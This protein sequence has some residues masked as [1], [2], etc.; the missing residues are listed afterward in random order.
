MNQLSSVT[1][2]CPTLC[3][4]MDCSTPGFPDHHQ[5]PELVQTHVHRVGDAIQPLHPLSS[6]SPAFNLS[7]H[8]DL[9]QGVIS[10]HQVAKVLEFQLQHQSF[11]W[12]FWTDNEEY[13]AFLI[14]A[15][16]LNQMAHGHVWPTDVS[17]L[18]VLSQMGLELPF[19]LQWVRML[20]PLGPRAYQHWAPPPT[21]QGPA[22]RNHIAMP[23][24]GLWF[25]QQENEGENYEVLP[26][27]SW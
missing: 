10:S 6:H 27:G 8:Q 14:I 15:Q 16:I 13:K 24:L 26:S 7:Q 19:P 20:M 18:P 3:N 23:I 21:P 25:F 1:Q 5:L 4:P 11:Q 17:S 22:P 2:S 9:F 12:I